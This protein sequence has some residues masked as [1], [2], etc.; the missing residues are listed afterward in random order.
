MRQQ[1]GNKNTKKEGRWGEEW[2]KVR[3]E[4]GEK[5]RETKTGKQNSNSNSKILFYKDCNLGSFKNLYNN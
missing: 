3:W 1:E 4:T 5:E 2:K